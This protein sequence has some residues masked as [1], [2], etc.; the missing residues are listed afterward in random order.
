[1]SNFPA[2]LNRP[3]MHLPS[4]NGFKKLKSFVVEYTKC[5][6]VPYKLDLTNK[7]KKTFSNEKALRKKDKSHHDNQ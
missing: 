3:K 7:K 6:L 4:I 2:T 1:M 5:P